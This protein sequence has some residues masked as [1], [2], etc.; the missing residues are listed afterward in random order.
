[1]PLQ[2][3]AETH[4]AFARA[5]NAGDLDALVALYES[6]AVLVYEPGHTARGL[7]A[8]REALRKFLS[9]A[10]QIKIETLSIIDSGGG[11]ALA[12]GRWSLRAVGPRD[13]EV[14]MRGRST[15]VLRQQPDGSWL[16]VIDNPYTPD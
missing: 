4:A 8:I 6:D 11:L 12:H 3:P 13:S 15:D 1:M 10:P 9:G 7:D 14:L 16:A 2:S 5:F